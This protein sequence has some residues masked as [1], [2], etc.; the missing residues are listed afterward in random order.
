MSDCKKKKIFTKGR[1]TFCCQTSSAAT[2][3]LYQANLEWSLISSERG[4]NKTTRPREKSLVS[5]RI[6]HLHSSRQNTHNSSNRSHNFFP[7]TKNTEFWASSQSP[8]LRTACAAA[9]TQTKVTSKHLLTF[10]LT[11]TGTSLLTKESS[12][13]S[14]SC[15]GTKALHKSATPPALPQSWE[16]RVAKITGH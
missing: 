11:T 2:K 14:N 10:R 6:K 5:L 9:G 16:N 15:D 12:S 8:Y 1:H 3:L 13:N 7:G 4:R